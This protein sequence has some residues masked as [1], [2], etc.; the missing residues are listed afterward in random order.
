MRDRKPGR[1]AEAVFFSEAPFDA[2]APSPH[3]PI[4]IVIGLIRV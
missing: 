4:V 3:K 1:V 2:L